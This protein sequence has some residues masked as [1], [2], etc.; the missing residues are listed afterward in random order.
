MY[1]GGESVD[2][3]GE[4]AADIVGVLETADSEDGNACDSGGAASTE[5]PLRELLERN[6]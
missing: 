6:S 3:F 4:V 1:E 2:V 5:A